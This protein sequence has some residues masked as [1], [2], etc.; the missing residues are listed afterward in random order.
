MIL[1]FTSILYPTGGQRNWIQ[2]VCNGGIATSLS[3]LYMVDTGFMDPPLDFAR[4]YDATWMAMAVVG[5]VAC[6]CGDTF[7][8]EI[9]SVI[10]ADQPR[11]ITTWSKVPVGRYMYGWWA[12]S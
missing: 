10:G 3:I 2:V 12:I 5:A 7:A 9:G 1:L 11:L 4:Y 8:S 6:C